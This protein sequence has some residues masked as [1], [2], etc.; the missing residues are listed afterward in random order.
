MLTWLNTNRANFQTFEFSPSKVKIQMS[1]F[2]SRQKS[3]SKYIDHF[4]RENS[5]LD[6]GLISSTFFF[7]ANCKSTKSRC[8][9]NQYGFFQQKL[10]CNAGH[11][12]FVL[13]R[14]DKKCSQ[15]KTENSFTLFYSVQSYHPS[16]LTLKSHRSSLKE[17]KR[18]YCILFA[19]T[20]MFD[21]RELLYT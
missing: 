14:T 7:F 9:D 15:N 1:L 16:I 8:C 20:D 5:K 10:Q 3:T 19:L 4:W 21:V 18:K 17:G 11:F 12:F 2:K 6:F 13:E